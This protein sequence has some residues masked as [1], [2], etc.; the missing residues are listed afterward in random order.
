MNNNSGEFSALN[1]NL[2]NPVWLSVAT[3]PLFDV[4]VAILGLAPASA[5]NSPGSSFYPNIGFWQGRS[6]WF[7]GISELFTFFI[8][9]Y[10]SSLY[11][12]KARQDASLFCLGKTRMDYFLG[13][14]VAAGFVV[15]GFV[16][17]G[18]GVS[19]ALGS[20]PICLS[21]MSVTLLSSEP[22]YSR[23]GVVFCPASEFR[24]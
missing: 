20:T 23:M 22:T 3:L 24:M 18:A 11:N 15:A 9:R 12:K 14:V 6:L 5:S 2:V 1:A 21:T 13:G 10:S 19:A 17:A 16:A 4:I 7:W 8:H